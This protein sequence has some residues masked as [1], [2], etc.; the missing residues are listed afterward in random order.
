VNDV[1]PARFARHIELALDAG[2]RFVP[3]QAIARG[4]GRPGDVALTFD[5][6][7]K[8]VAVNAAPAG[9]P[10]PGLKACCSTGAR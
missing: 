6:G 3:A 5:D 4:E 2:A 10:I 7:L 1:S 9:A 8:S